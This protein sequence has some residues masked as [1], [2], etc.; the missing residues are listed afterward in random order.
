MQKKNETTKKTKGLMDS[1]VF[2]AVLSLFL[3]L[4][5][6]VYYG[7]NY[8][9]EITRTFPGVEVTYVGRDAMRDSQS[10]IISR[11]D[12]TTV[13]LTLTGSRREMS[14]LTSES[15]KAVVNLSTVTSAGF[16]AMAYTISY[17]SS[18]NT[19][20][21]TE[22]NKL[23]QTVGLQI[24]KLAT[25]VVDVRGRFEGTLAEGYML[26]SAG[27]SFDPAYITLMGPEE[28]LDQVECASVVVDRDNVSASFVAAANYNL[29]NE[30]EEILSFDDVTVDVSTVTVTVPVNKMKEVALDVSLIEGGGATADNVSREIDPQT[31]T[32][33][34]DAATIDGINTVYIA[35][36][37]LSD[38]VTFPETEY[39]V[40]LPNGTD[41]VSGVTTAKVNLSFTG[42]DWAYF[43]VTNLEYTNLEEGYTADVMDV[44]LVV[45]IR[46]P[47]ETLSQIEAN[48][49]RAVADLSGITTTSK[50]PAAV[51]VDGFADAGA[52][53]DY[54]LYVRVQPYTGEEEAEE[55]ETPEEGEPEDA[56][57]GEG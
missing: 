51:Y 34:G 10:L 57:E 44:T 2:W 47:E 53:G 33:A 17:P 31:V 11:E 40:I 48:N 36:I 16:R 1:R 6:W 15:L 23:P 49:I 9:T 25:R 43:T 4:L 37:D 56:A 46:A 50:V 32:I 24:S 21:I 26:N 22:T 3:A 35:T 13:T 52:V 7:S 28:E 5:I 39:A 20:N 27:M 38:Y 14:K 41:N 12:V 54:T 29:V 8:G 18:V 55:G 45:T 30:D 19:A 42:L